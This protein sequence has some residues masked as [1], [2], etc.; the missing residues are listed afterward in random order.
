MVPGIIAFVQP[1]WH[2]ASLQQSRLGER[3]P[4][5]FPLCLRPICFTRRAQAS[6]A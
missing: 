2:L 6:Q 3:G 5:P 4:F 1:T